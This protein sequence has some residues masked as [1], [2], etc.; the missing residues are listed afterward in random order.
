MVEGPVSTTNGRNSG[1]DERQAL[2]TYF[3]RI[4]ESI[5]VPVAVT[6]LQVL[7]LMP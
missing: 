6:V 3:R 7:P 5:P 4:V 1:V 2:E